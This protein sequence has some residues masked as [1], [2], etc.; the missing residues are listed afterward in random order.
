MPLRQPLRFSPYPCEKVWGGERLRVVLGWSSDGH[1]PIGEVWTLADRPDVDSRV[2]GG[3]LHGRSLQELLRDD[4]TALLGSTRPAARGAFPLLVKLLDTR[5]NLSVQVHPDQRVARSLGGGAE[6]KTECWYVLA[7]EPGARLYL[8]LRPGVDSDRL[9]ALAASPGVVELLREWP[10]QAGQFVYVPPGTVHAIGA[11]ITLVEIQDNSDTTFRLYDWQ[12]AG[13]DGEPRRT[14][15]AQALRSIDYQQVLAGPVVPESQATGTGS[16][17]ATLIDCPA[18]RVEWLETN[19]VIS[20]STCARPL[21]YVVLAG[22][23]RLMVEGA[24]GEWPIEPWQTWL[25]PADVEGHRIEA[26]AG[27]LSLLAAVPGSQGE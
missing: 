1:S 17:G 11:G 25:L 15:V 20:R 4:R 13:L 10:I 7:A 12:R 19:A 24:D 3:G 18:F 14:H 2:Q 8:G 22:K 6:G 27:E 23:G 9:A 16:S 5:K 21:V 26:L